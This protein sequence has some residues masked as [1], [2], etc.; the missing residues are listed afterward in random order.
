MQ[1]FKL[2]IMTHIIHILIMFLAFFFA[3]NLAKAHN[4]LVIMLEPHFKNMKI[5]CDFMSDTLV[6]QIV[7]KYDTNILC[8]FFVTS[9]L[10]FE[11]Y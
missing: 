2:K 8:V 6:V 4:M 7:A 5:I 3:Y 1:E 11:P 9:V 10:S